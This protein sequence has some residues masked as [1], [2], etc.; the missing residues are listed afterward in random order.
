MLKFLRFVHIKMKVPFLSFEYTNKVIRSE[1]LTSFEDF[2]DRARYILGEELKS[3]EVEYAQFNR[4]KH[5]IGVS[6]G[7]DALILSLKALNIGP[8]DEVIVPSNTFIASALAVTHVGAKPVFVEPRMETYN[9]N[10]ELLESSITHKTKAIIP[11]HLYGQA[12]EMDLI[13]EI[14]T[15]RGL[16]VVE[17]NAQ[18]HGASWQGKL[19]GS[20]G[21]CNASSFYPGKNLGALGDGGV[22]TTNCTEWAEKI[23]ALRNYGSKEKYKN[24]ILGYNMR[25]DEIQ[26]AFLKVKLRHLIEWTEQRREI[27]SWYDEALYKMPDLHTPFTHPNATHSYH[28]YVIRTPNRDKLRSFLE[29]KGIGTLIHYPI[30]PHLQR[31]YSYLGYKEG[32]FPIAEELAREVLSLPLWPGMTRSMVDEI[33]E[34]IG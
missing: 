31:A 33:C 21:Q 29:E 30:P 32:D 13:L 10:P 1:I 20:F 8:G 2:F 28:L 24:E 17:D 19:T 15:A 16:F 22:V 4:V 9:L 5:A 27:A 25:L 6:N 11:V 14:A 18:A 23:K 26:A 7:L 34:L 3:F 12:C